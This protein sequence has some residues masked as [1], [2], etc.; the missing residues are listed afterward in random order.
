MHYN[1]YQ[2][3]RYF[4]DLNVTTIKKQEIYCLLNLFFRDNVYYKDLVHGDLH[5]YNWKVINPDSDYKIVIYDYGYIVKI[6]NKQSIITHSYSA[7][8]FSKTI[9]ECINAEIANQGSK[10][11]FSTGSQNQKPPQPNS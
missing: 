1:N 3:E 11:A 6:I 9:N 7:L 4:H 5:T 8:L 10:D 2:N